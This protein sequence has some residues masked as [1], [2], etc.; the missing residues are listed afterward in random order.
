MGQK[1]GAR[2][3]FARIAN[4]SNSYDTP[5]NSD[6]ERF[7]RDFCTKG[8]LLMRGRKAAIWTRKAAIWT[9]PKM[10]KPPFGRSQK[11]KSRHLDRYGGIA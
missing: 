10:E 3:F 8:N 7:L 1:S 9:L 2:P 5:T 6:G 11:W 4:R